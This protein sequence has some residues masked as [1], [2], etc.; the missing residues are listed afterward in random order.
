[1]DY[2]RFTIRLDSDNKY[3][4]QYLIHNK[5]IVEF[6]TY[7]RIS[8]FCNWL[9][10]KREYWRNILKNNM[11]YTKCIHRYIFNNLSANLTSG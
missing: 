9:Q 5:L 2:N 7:L 8:I 1:M 11:A 3:R 10:C 4:I 6:C